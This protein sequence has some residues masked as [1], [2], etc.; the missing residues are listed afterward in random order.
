MT[1]RKSRPFFLNLIL[2]RLPIA[3]IMS[4]VH[5]VSGVLMVLAIPLMIALLGYSL[6]GPEGFHTIGAFLH[7]TLGQG[8]LFLCLWGLMHHLLAGI[9][10]LLLDLDLGVER[11]TYRITAILVLVLSPLLAV[12]LTGGLI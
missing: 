11:P 9:R 3:G 10:Y 12:L 7:S 1:T 4:I 8:V 5:R 6:S 2:I